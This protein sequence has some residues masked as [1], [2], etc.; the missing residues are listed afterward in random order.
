MRHQRDPDHFLHDPAPA[1]PTPPL[2]A[3]RGCL[4]VMAV[5]SALGGA[6]WVLAWLFG[7]GW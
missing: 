3:V 1:D 6:V 5:W 2:G 4:L 7:R